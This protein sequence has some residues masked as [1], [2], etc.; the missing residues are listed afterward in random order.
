MCSRLYTDT[1][2]LRNLTRTLC[3][4]SQN[5]PF[6]L[7]LTAVPHAQSTLFAAEPS[8]FRHASPA[9]QVP[10]PASQYRPLAAVHNANGGCLIMASVHAQSTSFASPYVHG[11]AKHTLK[12]SP[13]RTVVASPLQFLSHF[14]TKIRNSLNPPPLQ[15]VIP[16]HVK[17]T[18]YV[19]IVFR[20]KSIHLKH[21]K[22]DVTS[23][24]QFSFGP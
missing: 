3:A 6:T 1:L 10:V 4:L 16:V 20:T 13:L 14:H 24:S 18:Q 7:L 8:M 17:H 9:P 12:P 11:S 21:P 23:T 15:S 22:L 5:L 19:P 2:E